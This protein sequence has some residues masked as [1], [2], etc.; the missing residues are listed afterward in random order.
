MRNKLRL[1]FKLENLDYDIVQYLKQQ[2]RC[3]ETTIQ[4]N[5][6]RIITEYINSTL[7][8][9][10]TFDNW[11]FFINYAFLKDKFI[12]SKTPDFLMTDFN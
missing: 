6:N 2:Y 12:L 5:R 4:M 9:P 3:R 8:F 10:T 7:T 11:M 1:R